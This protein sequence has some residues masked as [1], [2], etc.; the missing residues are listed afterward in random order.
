MTAKEVFERIDDNE[1]DH[2]IDI[3]ERE[4]Y[5]RPGEVYTI[6]GKSIGDIEFEGALNK[7]RV[8][9]LRLSNEDEEVIKSIAN[10]L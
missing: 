10:N 7:L 4:D 5:I 3:L 9:R 2:L 1:I 8:N 6:Y